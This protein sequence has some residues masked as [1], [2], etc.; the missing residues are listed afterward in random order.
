MRYEAKYLERLASVYVD[1]YDLDGH[2]A[3]QDWFTE[4]LPRELRDLVRPYITL[5][6]QRRQ[7]EER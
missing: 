7:R 6:V 3:A 4:F 5:E 1:H 2:E